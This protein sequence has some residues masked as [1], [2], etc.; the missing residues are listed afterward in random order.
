M[1]K[2]KKFLGKINQQFIRAKSK[3]LIAP[4]SDEKPEKSILT[5][6]NK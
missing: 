6:Q 5:S 2:N 1:L 4:V 3:P